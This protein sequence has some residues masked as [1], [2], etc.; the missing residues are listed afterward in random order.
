MRS[1]ALVVALPV[2]VGSA[3]LLLA[4]ATPPLPSPEATEVWTPVPRVVT[5]GPMVAAAPPSDAIV[6]FDGTSLDEWVNAADGSP[7]TWQVRSGLMVVNKPSGNIQTR[8]TFSSYQLH[9]E[10]SVPAGVEGSG[11]ARGNSG[12]FLASTGKGDGGYEL[13]ILDSFENATYVNGQAASIYKQAPPLVNATRRPGEW[14]V[15][16]VVWSAP[17][18]NADGTLRSPAVVTVF[19]NG[20]LVQDGFRLRLRGLRLRDWRRHGIRRLTHDDRLWLARCRWLRGRFRCTAGRW[21]RW[22]R[23][24]L[25]GDEGDVDRPDDLL[26]LG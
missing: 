7:A 15:Y 23:R 20:V 5:P 16:D 12:V 10:W 6:L 9:L 24:R 19:H 14:N 17:V 26:D 2:I 4:Q 11:Q 8:R 25:R 21:R 1:R 18:F 13:Q 3:A 22:G